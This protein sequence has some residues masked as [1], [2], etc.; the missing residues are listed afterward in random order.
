MAQSVTVGAAPLFV[1][2]RDYSAADFRQ[3]IASAL[4]FPGVRGLDVTAGSG[5]KVTVA[6]GLA[7]AA[8]TSGGFYSARI[9]TA[10]TLDLPA[11]QSTA[12][13]HLVVVRF[14]DPQA[15]DASGGVV[16]EV[17]TGTSSTAAPAAPARSVALAQVGVPANATGISQSNIADVS[18]VPGSSGRGVDSVTFDT[19]GL[20]TIEHNLGWTPRGGNYSFMMQSTGSTNID[21]YPVSGG[22]TTTTAR[23]R[24]FK[25]DG[26]AFAGTLSAV[27]WIVWR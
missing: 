2:D 1:I 24:A 12:R 15:G 4:E 7:M 27:Q 9:A 26:T 14:L 23:V 25:P 20:G 8:D 22:F 21:L 11:A 19:G 17:V 10:T 16:L 3:L 18:Q 13:I 6:P 5:L